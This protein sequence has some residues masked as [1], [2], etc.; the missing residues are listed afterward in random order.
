MQAERIMSNWHGGKG[1]KRRTSNEK[2]YADNWDKIFGAKRNNII[3]DALNN[4]AKKD[5]TDE[6]CDIDR[7][8]KHSNQK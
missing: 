4:L 3:V 8:E 1:S 7:V 6:R 5:T 2:A